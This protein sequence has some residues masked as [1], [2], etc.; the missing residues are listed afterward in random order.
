MSGLVNIMV[1][2]AKLHLWAGVSGNDK[3]PCSLGAYLT[4]PWGYFYVNYGHKIQWSHEILLPFVRLNLIVGDSRHQ[5]HS[6]RLERHSYRRR[7]QPVGTLLL[8][9]IQC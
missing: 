8:A 7:D 5:G 1:G 4:L 3:I 9:S 2:M 6:E